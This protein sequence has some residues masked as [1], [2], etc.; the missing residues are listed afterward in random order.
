MDHPIDTVASLRAKERRPLHPGKTFREL[1]A[2]QQAQMATLLRGP[3]PRIRSV[4]DFER[5][6]GGVL[7]EVPR[8]F[9]RKLRSLLPW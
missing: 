4:D 1:G 2:A 8:P 9:W 6:A 7:D 3:A 5:A